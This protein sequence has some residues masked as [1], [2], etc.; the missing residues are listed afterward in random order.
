MVRYKIFTSALMVLTVIACSTTSLSYPMIQDDRQSHSE[1]DNSVNDPEVPESI[2]DH[3]VKTISEKNEYIKSVQKTLNDVSD[4]P[5]K[6]MIELK[7]EIQELL[8]E[9]Y[10]QF[11]YSD[12]LNG[13]RIPK[14]FQPS[15]W[16]I[17]KNNTE[18]TEVFEKFKNE[19]EV[20]LAN[21]LSLAEEERKRIEENEAEEKES[22]ANKS[23]RNPKSTASS[24][25]PNKKPSSTPKPH[26]N[27]TFDQRYWRLAKG[28]TV[29]VPPY[30]VVESCNSVE[31]RA[32]GCYTLGADYIKITQ[33]AVE[34]SDCG[35]REVIAHE[36]YHY[37][38]WVNHLY[39]FSN[40]TMGYVTNEAEIEA[41]AY[42][43]DDRFGC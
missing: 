41:A 18:I 21:Y 5:S 40:G 29:P 38:Q 11:V 37:Y 14:H 8:N 43:Y 17:E 39:E 10:P 35:L 42:A 2:T 12:F 22:A 7:K 6:E 23:P 26:S 13:L 30:Q 36:S 34:K 16:V 28:I 15:P 3:L 4:S 27:E 1:T 31:P 20:K 25:Q 33:R 19:I 32:I 24:S 9:D